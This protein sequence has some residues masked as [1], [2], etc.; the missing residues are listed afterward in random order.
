VL[1][2]SA[3]ARPD[4]LGGVNVRRAGR[5]RP[6]L[7]VLRFYPEWARELSERDRVHTYG[8]FHIADLEEAA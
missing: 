3:H 8:G 4:Y 6:L 5:Q 7:E 1:F 2:R